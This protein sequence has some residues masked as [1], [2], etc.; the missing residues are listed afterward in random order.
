M[1]VTSSKVVR[2]VFTT[3]G[4]GSF[5]I[6]LPNPRED[7]QLPEIKAVMESLIS[8]DIFLTTSGALTG[9]RDIKIIDTTVNDLY[10]PLAD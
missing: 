1:A 4:G 6:T 5:T 9:I 10:D 7:L 2:L 3:S 8:S